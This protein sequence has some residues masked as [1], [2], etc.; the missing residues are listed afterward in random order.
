M[1]KQPNSHNEGC[2]QA[3][4]L[5]NPRPAL[6]PPPDSTYVRPMDIRNTWDSKQVTLHKKKEPQQAYRKI[7]CEIV[8]F[9][10][11]LWI[12]RSAAEIL[13]AFHP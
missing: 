3:E 9:V 11:I 5:T 2:S 1:L 7:S 10:D 4:K 8:E 6:P 13:R 12:L